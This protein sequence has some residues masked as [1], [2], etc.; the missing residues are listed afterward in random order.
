MSNT[1]HIHPTAVVEDGAT[2][3]PDAVVGPFCFVSRHARIGAGTKLVAHVSVLGRTTLGEHNTIWP[4]ATLGAEP[5]DL[6]FHGEAVTLAIGHHN[7]IRE[8]VT[9]HPGTGNGGGSTIVGSGNLI[10]VGSHIG[11]D[12]IVGNHVIL[13]NQVQ[14]AGHVVIEDHANIAGIVGVHHY[15]TIG[16]YSYVG[17]MTRVVKDVTPFMLYE[18]DPARERGVNAIGLQRHRIDP[19]S[20]TRLKDAFKRLFRADRKAAKVN[21][22]GKPTGVI[23]LADGLTSL[24][25][26]YGDDAYISILA[27]FLRNRSIG[28]SGRYRE[29]LREDDRRRNVSSLLK[30]TVAVDA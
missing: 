28:T 22:N 30:K 18:G 24:E 19:V 23:N 29:T 15:C 20:I 21:G 4:Q 8:N 2:V 26:D 3:H 11:H 6:K 12:C 16:Q 1:Y 13:A 10:M 27:T 9:I 14:L 25:K 7:E 5:Q 17:G